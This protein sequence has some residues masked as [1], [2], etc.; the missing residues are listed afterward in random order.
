[1][2]VCTE[3]TVKAGREYVGALHMSQAAPYTVTDEGSDPTYSIANFS[4]VR[5]ARIRRRALSTYE[6]PWTIVGEDT[7]AKSGHRRIYAE[8]VAE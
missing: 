3:T 4:P 1:M 6:V 5:G 2:R 7:S 8:E